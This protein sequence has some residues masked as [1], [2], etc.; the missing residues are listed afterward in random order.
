MAVFKIKGKAK[1]GK[2]WKKYMK[3]RDYTAKKKRKPSK[4]SKHLRGKVRRPCKDKYKVKT[5]GKNRKLKPG[6]KKAC[7]IMKQRKKTYDKLL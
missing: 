4:W 2:S 5:I 6:K 7:N 3:S 1:A